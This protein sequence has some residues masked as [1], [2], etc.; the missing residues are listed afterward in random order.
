[1]GERATL[2]C[3][4]ASW[5]HLG[6]SWGHLGRPGG[7]LGRL[8]GLLSRLWVL[9]GLGTASGAS[10]PSWDQRRSDIGA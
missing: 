3:M 6:L 1:M 7:Q 10:G 5:G 2:G 8:G 4:E 9:V